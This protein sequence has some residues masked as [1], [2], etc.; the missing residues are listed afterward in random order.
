MA[1]VIAKPAR[2]DKKWN[3]TRDDSREAEIA[4]DK[5][6]IVTMMKRKRDGTKPD[7]NHAPEDGSAPEFTEHYWCWTST[8]N[9]KTFCWDEATTSW[10]EKDLFAQSK[11]SLF[12]VLQLLIRLA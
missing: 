6:R 10:M 12:A 3:P 1:Y 5:R 4:A 7:F 2:D 8:V 11:L 9:G